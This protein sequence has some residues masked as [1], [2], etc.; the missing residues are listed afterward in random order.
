MRFNLVGDVQNRGGGDEG[1]PTIVVEL[2]WWLGFNFKEKL[3]W[4][5]VEEVHPSLY[6]G[7]RGVL[8]D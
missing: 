1:A 6:K 8:K 3:A 5:C 2:G 4:G 7:V